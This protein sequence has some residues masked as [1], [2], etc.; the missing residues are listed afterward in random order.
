MADERIDV[1]VTDKV[2]ASVEKKLEGIASAAERAE[3][4]LNRLKAA[5]ANVN[6]T[7]VDRLAAAMA[8]ADTAQAK[9]ISAQARLTNAQNAGS[10]AAE[11]VALAQ[12][13][14]AT[15]AARTEAA[16]ARAA[17][18]TSGAALAAMRLQAAASATTGASAG[19]A[20]AQQQ[21]ATATTGAG[22]A[23]A[24]AGNQ[25]RAYINTMTQANTQ[26][27]TG[28]GAAG[29]VAGGLNNTA[30]AHMN[31]QRAARQT[32]AVNANIIA[33]LQDIGVSLA[34]GQNPLLVMIQQGSQLSYIASTM[35]GGLRALL[36]TIAKMALAWAPVIVAIGAAYLAFRSFTSA[37]NDHYPIDNYVKSLGLTRA[38][39]KKLG[40][41][42]I[43]MGDT[44]KAT[45]QVLSENVLS[46][47]GFTT[48]QIK[49]FWSDMTQKVLMWSVAAFLGIGAAAVTLVKWIAVTV[50][51]IPKIFYNAGVGAANLFLMGIE[52]LVNGVADG[53]NK[54]GGWI[55]GLSE[56][57][58][59][60]RVVGDF[61]HISLGVKGVTDGMVELSH[62]DL[63]SEF[64]AGLN[65][66]LNTLRRIGSVAD[67]I[68]RKRLKAKADELKADRTPKKVHEPKPKVDHTAENRAH[69]I[70]QVNLKLDDELKRMHM[71][72]DERE[73]QQR[74]DSIEESL[75]QKKIHLN[76]AERLAIEKKVRAI[77]AYKYVQAEMDRIYE[78][79][80]GPERTYQAALAATQE[81]LD[82]NAISAQ[83][84]SQERVLAARA[85]A[86][87]NDPLF[88]M[89]EALLQ[90][91]GASKLYGDAV[92]R[93][94]YYEEIRQAYLAKGIILGQNSTK[95]IDDEV[96][97]MMRRNDALAQQQYVQTQVGAIVNPILE[98]QKLLDNKAAF[99]AE[100]DRLRQADALS[101]EQ[102]QRAKYAL[103]AK[104]SEL[105]LAGASQ[106]FGTLAQLSSSGNRKLALIGKAAA[107]AQTT[108]DG[109]VA[110][111]KALASG[112]PPWNM[113]NA[114]AIAA[115]TGANVARIISTPVGGFATGGQFMV[116][117]KSGVD[118]NN[119]NMNVT[120]GER[121]TVETP[122][123]QRANDSPSGD[124]TPANVNVKAVTLFDPRNMLDAINSSEGE[125]VII[126]V[127][128]RRASEISR[129]LG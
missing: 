104:F 112:P 100:I 26:A 24:G 68:R 73:I 116:E 33:Q 12:Q 59:L 9:L 47:M 75:A 3:S 96:A 11:K 62:I 58:G 31:Y 1:V 67:D 78:S 77:E 4:Y 111:Q 29:R 28:A 87:A 13:R 35:Q 99:Y 42:H 50:V 80:I 30:G 90:A 97:A 51:N 7:A 107:I 40:D 93:N 6:A 69:A 10:I 32:T 83:R 91:E 72:K 128:E 41:T 17:Q 70:A 55:N 109:I 39:L 125:R 2:D 126:S 86:Q 117:G 18:A 45:W 105:R 66:G 48:E 127:V 57:A 27:A 64:Q 49:S 102:A 122:A 52:K 37:L 88:A 85:L 36:L 23:A 44:I 61:E 103:D 21:L 94:N 20:N 121:V 25:W 113:I 54:I 123:Q 82:K 81:L 79:V 46:S 53:M 43:T 114:A 56:K 129:I 119:I 84:A 98:D 22:T 74:M 65:N 92:A 63:K 16:Q 19:A 115:M 108:I 71:L 101:E 34:G 15:E 89:K 5:L 38:E 124:G 95:A 106:F 120:R 14:L 118:A 8:K 76:D 110:V 60:G